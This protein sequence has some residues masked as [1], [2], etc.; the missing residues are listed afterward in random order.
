MVTDFNGGKLDLRRLNYG[1]IMLVP[2]TKETNTIRQYRSICLLKVDFK[3]F[4]MLMTDRIT[5]RVGKWIDESQTVFIKGRNILEGAVILHKFI[6]EFKKSSSKGVIFKINFKKAYDKVRWAFVQQ[7][8]EEKGFPRSW[9]QDA[10]STIQGGGFEL[11]SME[12]GQIILERSKVF[13]KG[14]HCHPFCSNLLL[15]C[16]QP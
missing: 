16:W 10:M 8:L 3:I 5:P 4:P 13:G 7:V 6:H 12:T 14:I 11:M 1:V 2:K 9:I 15:M